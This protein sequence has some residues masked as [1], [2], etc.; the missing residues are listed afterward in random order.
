MFVFKAFANRFAVDIVL[1]VVPLSI[2][3]KQLVEIPTSK[4]KS[5]CVKPLSL[6]KTKTLEP[7]FLHKILSYLYDFLPINLILSSDLTNSKLWDSIFIS[8]LQI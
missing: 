5:A 7:K 1:S 2:E 4:A 8:D 6:R 3:L